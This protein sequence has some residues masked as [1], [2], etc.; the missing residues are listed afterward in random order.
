MN[1]GP[2]EL[3]VIR[4]PGNEVRGRIAPTLEELVKAGT[5]RII[6]LMLAIKDDKGEVAVL[7]LG[8][9]DA[10]EYAAIDPLV[11]VLSGMLTEDDARQ[12]A[13]PLEPNSAIGILLFEH[14]W[15]QK[16]R[17]AVERSKGELLLDERVPGT[18]VDQLESALPTTFA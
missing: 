11:E 2:I 16:F 3:L 1:R 5:I 13:K 9:L 10:A 6:D 4:F 8:D 15:V 14:T 12:L 7:E 18:V 17:T